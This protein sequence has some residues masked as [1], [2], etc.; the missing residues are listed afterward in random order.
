[1]SDKT[2]YPAFLKNLHRV[3]VMGLGR[4]GGGV[5]AARFFAELGADVI[6]TDL[7]EETVLADSVAKLSGLPIIFRLGVHRMKD[8]TDT[9]LVLANQAARPDNPFL[10]AARRER[11]PILTETGLALALNRSPWLAV[12]GSSG[13][14]TTA[15]LMADMLLRHDPATLFGGNIGGDL[16][17]RV[18]GRPAES[19][20][21]AELSSFQ[22]MHIGP[23]LASG[24]IAP[25][26][27]AVIT[28]ITPNHLDWHR[29][30]AEYQNSKRHLL[31]RQSPAD[32]AVLN[33]D[34]PLLAGWADDAPGRVIATSLADSGRSDAGFVKDDAIVLRLDGAERLSFP[35]SRLRLRGRHNVMNAIQAAAAA[36]VFHEDAGAVTE[37]AAAFPGLPHR[38][39]EVA[40]IDGRVFV[41]DSKSTTPEAAVLA[42]ESIPGDK[43]LIA[44]GY[45]K[46]SPF[47]LLG[48]AI[49]REAAA[50]VLVGAAAER[51]E[52]AVAAAAAVRPADRPPL[53]VHVC[54]DDF[55]LAVATAFEACPPGGVVLL[56][57]AC[58][59][60]GMFSD[61]ENRGKRFRE[62]SLGLRDPC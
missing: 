55:P 24:D 60:W 17:T 43:V 35:V 4:F 7:S 21:A 26:S 9:D 8:F 22:L 40:E 19:P 50:L 57:P 59:S 54:G 5:G 51:L 15:T 6:V 39:E 31:R 44:G 2:D 28:N 20:L 16:L 56:S 47:D 18:G 30:L 3:T 52:K 58:A 45:D 1:M 27:V 23:Q 53:P 41:N 48:K 42:L 14:S 33:V 12:T 37:A 29:D 11:I 46:Q 32:W 49:Q 34:D 38:L 10:E 25:P 36:F 61:F 62:L 13:K